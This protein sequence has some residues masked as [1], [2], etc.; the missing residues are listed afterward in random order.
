[1]AKILV[2]DD[3]KAIVE[4]VAYFAK[5]HDH[6]IEAAYGGEAGLNMAFV[7]KPDIIVLDQMM[8]GMDGKKVF[9]ELKRDPR[10]KKI[11]IIFLTAKAQVEDRI[12]GLELG[13]DDYVTKPFSLKELMLR[14]EAVLKRCEETPGKV[15][16][17]Y[18]PFRFDKNHM[19]FY[20]DEEPVDLTATE[21]KLLLYMVEN[22]GK[23]LDRTDLFRTILG[24][25]DSV[26]S[27]TLD[28]HMKR[29]RQKIEPYADCIE[30]IRNVGYR[31]NLPE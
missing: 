2:I 15:E 28:M 22:H 18:G 31:F 25:S 30:T 8:P 21:F 14:V 12:Q 10:T 26:Y 6:T 29:A 20:L 16:A 3:E 4:L 5:K 9:Q 11:P 1:M 27:R 13:A 23:A 17:S 24:Y 19:K 7:C